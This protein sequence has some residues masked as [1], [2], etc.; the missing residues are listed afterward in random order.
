[1]FEVIKLELFRFRFPAI[2]QDFP[3][4]IFL[5]EN[6]IFAV[7]SLACANARE[8]VNPPG[9]FNTAH[10][11]AGIE[12]AHVRSV[13]EPVYPNPTAPRPTASERVI[14]GKGH[15]SSF[16]AGPGYKRHGFPVSSKIMRANEE[17]ADV[18][19]VA[20]LIGNHQSIS[21]VEINHA[22][23]LLNAGGRIQND[24]FIAAIDGVAPGVQAL[25]IVTKKAVGH[26]DVALF[27]HPE[28][29]G[30]DALS[31]GGELIGIVI[32]VSVNVS[33]DERSRRAV[34]RP[35]KIG[36]I[37]AV[38]PL[39]DQ[40]GGDSKFAVVTKNVYEVASEHAADKHES[41]AV[42]IDD[43]R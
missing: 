13:T 20:P 25:K 6:E 38:A 16:R 26:P 10:S 37:K 12:H 18:T 31:I 28:R 24:Y 22:R 35:N 4:V 43:L 8:K 21:I 15:A 41:F 33:P 17:P 23:N 30:L 9:V 14:A 27:I 34:W 1:M 42:Y 2:K 32:A 40:T 36:V 19:H 11:L 39:K 5:D 29:A 3:L 7:A